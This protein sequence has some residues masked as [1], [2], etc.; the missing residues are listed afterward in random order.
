VPARPGADTPGERSRRR[1]GHS[2]KAT[3]SCRFPRFWA[4]EPEDLLAAL[5]RSVDEAKGR[6][7]PARRNGGNGGDGV[8]DLSKD[9]LLERA[10][11]LDVPGRSKMSKDELAA[12]V[13]KAQR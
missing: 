5:R 9:E 7:R 2:P 13:K 11:R 10:K 1:R 8:G 4:E 3:R 6:R 12:A